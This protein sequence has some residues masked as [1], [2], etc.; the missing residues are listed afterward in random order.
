[1]LDCAARLLRH[2]D[3]VLAVGGG[4]GKGGAV[5]DGEVQAGGVGGEEDGYGVE[6]AGGRVFIRWETELAVAGDIDGDLEDFWGVLV[7]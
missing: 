4:G 6:L 7:G 2:D 1:M 5:G 3:A